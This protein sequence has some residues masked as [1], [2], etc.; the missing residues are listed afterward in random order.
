MDPSR[1]IMAEIMRVFRIESVTETVHVMHRELVVE[2]K[3]VVRLLRW[4]FTFLGLLFLS[5]H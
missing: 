3:M 4:F 2:I 1:W 5:V